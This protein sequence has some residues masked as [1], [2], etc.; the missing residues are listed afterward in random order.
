MRSSG[1]DQSAFERWSRRR[2]FAATCQP[3]S[4]AL[5]VPA[6]RSVPRS[7]R[8][9]S[10]RV[11]APLE[12]GPGPPL[13][14]LALGADNGWLARRLSARG[15]LVAAIDLSDHPTDGLG[16]CRHYGELSFIT[17]QTSFDRLPFASGQA[18][19]VVF[20]ASLHY[21]VEAGQTLGEALR[22][23]HSGGRF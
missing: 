15:H 19:L 3:A 20:D 22:V 12:L 6:R 13:H 14:I 18:D 7:Y 16:A 21:A 2:S 8:A 1:S 23:L 10:D 17:F 5:T 11:L 4:S 9:F